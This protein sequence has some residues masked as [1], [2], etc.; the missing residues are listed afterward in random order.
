MPL[1][2]D[3]PCKQVKSLMS[4]VLGFLEIETSEISSSESGKMHLYYSKLNPIGRFPIK[5]KSENRY[6]KTCL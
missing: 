1:C 6:R 3:E 5:I 4:K 2:I